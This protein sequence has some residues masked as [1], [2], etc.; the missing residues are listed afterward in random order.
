MDTAIQEFYRER[1][2]YYD[3][4]FQVIVTP[5]IWMQFILKPD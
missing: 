2:R 3:Q 1:A 5:L 4:L